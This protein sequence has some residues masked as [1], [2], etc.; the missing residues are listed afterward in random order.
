MRQPTLFSDER[1]EETP[2]ARSSDPVTSHT[3]AEKIKRVVTA[4]HAMVLAV[5]RKAGQPMTSAELAKA[6]CD[7]YCS[8][9]ATEPVLYAKKLDNFRKRAD[10][11]KRNPDLCVI[12]NDERNGGQLF[13]P[14]E[15]TR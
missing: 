10:E 7:E 1:S 13:Q 11:I 8:E 15:S 14:K 6:C 9:L 12:L 5:L 4:M 2:I 3:A